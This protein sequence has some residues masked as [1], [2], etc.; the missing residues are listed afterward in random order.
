MVLL[1]VPLLPEVIESD[2]LLP[3]PIELGG[4]VAAVPDP[5]VLPFEN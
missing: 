4:V 1:L 3:D 5:V 2:A